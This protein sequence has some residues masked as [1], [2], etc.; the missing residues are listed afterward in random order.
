[1][2]NHSIMN[3]SRLPISFVLALYLPAALFVQS[4]Q[5]P[6]APPPASTAIEPAPAQQDQG[7]PILHD[8]IPIKLEL[9][10]KLDSHTAKTNDALQFQVV[11]DVIVEGVRVLRRGTVVTGTV[12]DAS[13]SK[14]MG[15]AGRV[16]FTIGDIKLQD[17]AMVAVRAFNRSKGENRTGDMIVA[18]ASVPVVAAPFFLLMHGDNTVFPKGTEITAFVNGDV[19]LTP[20]SFAPPP[21]PSIR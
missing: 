5:N 17:G 3:V 13:S 7:P 20:V 8:G 6:S 12:T 19:K 4:V 1:M 2:L 18:M 16:S 10:A 14:N 21:D 11:N 15:R 9:M